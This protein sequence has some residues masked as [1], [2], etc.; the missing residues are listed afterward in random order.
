[1]PAHSPTAAAIRKVLASTPN[2]DP[3]FAAELQALA[4]EASSIL[5]ENLA[6]EGAALALHAQAEADRIAQLPKLTDERR[7]AIAAR[8]AKY[9]QRP[10]R[11]FTY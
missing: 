2:V 1:M 9:A 8:R 10:R 3:I 6:A 5:A 4:N 11:T 7:A